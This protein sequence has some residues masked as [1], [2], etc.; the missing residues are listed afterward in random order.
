MS[1]KGLA[2]AMILAVVFSAHAGSLAGVFAWDDWQVVWGIFEAPVH[3]LGARALRHWTILWD[4]WVWQGNPFG[5]HLTNL[6]LHG[7]GA[8]GVWA[9]AGSL[10]LGSRAALI[11][12]L[13]Y[14]VHPILCESL[15]NVANRKESLLVLLV[16][17]SLLLFLRGRGRV[18]LWASF[19]C[20]VLAIFAKETAVAAPALFF[21][22]DLARRRSRRAVRFGDHLPFWGAAAVGGWAFL[23]RTLGTDPAERLAQVGSWGLSRGDLVLLS[24][25]GFWRSVA[26]LAFPAGLS[27]EH[28]FAWRAGAGLPALLLL[29]LFSAAALWRLARY[30]G[31]GWTWSAGWLWA[32]AAWL[33]ASVAVDAAAFTVAERYW[34]LPWAGLALC[35]G[36]S[37]E[38][39]ER[40]FRRGGLAA[41]LVL[42][43][44]WV[45][46]SA[47][48]DR[49]W[50]SDI[51]LAP[52]TLRIHPRSWMARLSRANVLG[53][54]FGRAVE[55]QGQFARA[56]EIEPRS[57][58]VLYH[59]GR[60]D[61]FQGRLIPARARF[62]EAYARG[63]V[64]ALFFADAVDAAVRGQELAE[65]SAWLT[66]AGRIGR[67][68]PALAARLSALEAAW[69]KD[70][71]QG[72]AREEVSAWIRNQSEK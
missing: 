48:R 58:H 20:F 25:E 33:P 27:A 4:H 41:A 19:V 46:G 9:L 15:A 49:D 28:P 39:T 8:V 24:A 64:S 62:K 53:Y 65:A 35:G 14:G 7:A 10:A 54:R 23:L 44:L 55:A 16:T 56:Y 67:G 5:Y 17:A 21:L 13:A 59:W 66:E 47:R 29:G 63:Y 12:G 1:R 34:A 31:V 3:S 6:L 72:P 68:G 36:G 61:L 37:L 52:A 40:R 42:L 70:N 11:A 60:W 43:G 45:A 32:V 22:C 71:V 57:P 2:V 18:G 51:A 69:E 26:L 38:R 30:P 50:R